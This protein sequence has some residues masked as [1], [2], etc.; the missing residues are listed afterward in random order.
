MTGPNELPD[1]IRKGFRLPPNAD[2]LDRELDDEIAFHIEARVEELVARG[3]S[4]DAARAEALKR[5]GD[6]EDLRHYVSS[7]EVPHMQRVR[8]VE[9]IESLLQDVRVAFRQFVHAPSF[10]LVSAITLALGVG[11]STAIFSVVRGVLLRPLPFAQPDRIVQLWQQNDK[12]QAA[13]SDPNYEDLRDQSR[14]FQAIAQMSPTSVVSVG[15]LAE[16]VRAQAAAVSRDFFKVMRVAPQRGRLFADDET[17]EGGALVVLISDQFWKNTLGAGD[18]AIGKRLTIEG[19]SFTVVG[20]MPPQMDFPDKAQLWVP[21]EM[22]GRLPSR[23]AHNW[24]V[25]A[26]LA[27]GV[28]LEQAA[29]DASGIAR[30][31]KQRLGS[32]TAMTGVAIVPLQD[33]LVGRTKQTLLMLLAGSMLLLLI[34]CANVVNLLIARMAGRQAESALRIALGAGRWRL[35]QQHVVE[36]SMLALTAAFIALPLAY[37]GIRALLLLAPPNLPRTEEIRL[38]GGVLLF[39]IGMSALAAIVMGLIAAF[40]GKERDLRAAL[41]QSQRTQGSSVSADRARRGLVV[42]QVAMAVVLLVGAGL[43]ARSFARLLSVPT[44]FDVRGQVI[45]E[46]MNAGRPAERAQIYD[47][48]LR[49]FRALPGVTHAGGVSVMPLAQSSGPNGTFI[50]LSSVTDPTTHEQLSSIR[51][52]RER[53]GDAE[54]RVAGPGYFDAMGIS[55]QGGRLFEERDAAGA[56]HVAVISQQLA[57]SQWPGQDPIGKVIQY[58]NMDGDRTPIT[59][60][61]VVSDVRESLARPPQ[62]TFYVSYRQRPG[63]AWR[64]NFVLATSADPTAIM[65]PA[66]AV[67]RGVRPDVP[68]RVRAI[69]GVLASSVSDRRFVLTLVGV[70]GGAALLLAAL[71]VYSVISYLVTQREREIGIRVA[72]GAR[73]Q[74]IMRMVLAQGLVMAFAGIALGA[75]LALAATRL[76]EKMLWGVSATDSVAFGGVIVTLVIVALLA[77]WVPARRASR[78]HAMEVMR[79]G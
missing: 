40:R 36:A 37:G 21:R 17:K 11:A 79:V 9:W 65:N 16:P 15:G 67:V 57:E 63:Q 38:D 53:V 8:V 44:G 10:V 48:M 55:L 42:A 12:S 56:P 4:P 64:F 35:V 5:F 45:V 22:E 18:D 78:V 30:Q 62:P 26:R 33:Q 68:P 31:L 34:A 60:V 71:G 61:G 29:N 72:L 70:F 14:S 74:D 75:A 41:A 25:I 27:D 7:I 3:M 46:V 28:T 49:R 59:I 66:R 50:V 76:V 6:R 52:N 58:G 39:A 1:G 20:I 23:T 54:Y 2:R 51:Q 13:F 47:E 73:S 69:E 24:Q 19:N 77:S 32:E 43:F